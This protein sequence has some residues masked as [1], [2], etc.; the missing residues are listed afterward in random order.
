VNRRL[1]TLWVAVALGLAVPVLL[2]PASSGAP[3]DLDP[4]YGDHGIAA[5]DTGG[6]DFSVDLALQPDG[7]V[8]GVGATVRS[9]GNYDALVYRLDRSGHLDAGFGTRVL[10]ETGQH[11]YAASVTLQPDGKVVVVGQTTLNND[12]AVWRLLADGRPDTSF[13][14]DGLATLD[15][16]GLEAAQDVAVDSAGSVVVVGRST[17]GANGSMTIYRLTSSGVPDATFDGDGALGIDG[18][19]Y[20]SGAAVAVLPDRRILV[21]G[22]TSASST[23]RVYRLL[24]TGA[25]DTSFSGDGIVELPA[26]W[27][28]RVFDLDLR[29]DGSVY[30]LGESYRGSPDGAVVLLTSNGT[31]DA[32]FGGP[33]GAHL[34]VGADESFNSLAETPD[35]DIVLAGRTSAGT[36]P[37]VARLRSDG[38]PDDTFG[39]AGVVRLGGGADYVAGAAVQP[40]G[41]ILVTGDNGRTNVDA[42]VYRLLGDAEV[43]V[44]RCHGKRATIVGT[45]GKDRIRGTNKPDVIVALGGND[46][47]KGRGGKD[48]ICG[49]AGKDRLYGGAGR[50]TVVGG[51]GKDVVVQGG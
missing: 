25:P 36:D 47:V 23:G 38:T 11:E 3:A 6:Q 2:G 32:R 39:A 37:L 10:G 30:V 44:Q 15:S 20:D 41:K 5:A 46:V 16:G 12:I 9:G 27:S 33:T 18:P 51:P 40:D 35:G 49:G 45:S 1:G 19:G 31:V 22:D 48:V 26:P 8:V 14:R 21:A 4:T 29:P 28:N 43:T 24:A 42:I 50:D 17:V 13:G 7:K 34:D